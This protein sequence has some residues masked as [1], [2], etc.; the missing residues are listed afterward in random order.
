MLK[1]MDEFKI[2]LLTEW[3]LNVRMKCKCEK[4]TYYNELNNFYILI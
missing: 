2:F 1:E 3:K 4:V